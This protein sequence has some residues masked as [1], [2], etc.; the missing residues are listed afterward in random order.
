MIVAVTAW[1]GVGSTTTALLLAAHARSAGRAT[2]LVETDPAGG[3]LAGRIGLPVEAVGGLER[4][5]FP[6]AAECSLESV[7]ADWH[8]VRL[9][10]APADPFRAHACHHPSRQ[11]LPELADLAADA[12]VVIDIGRMRAASPSAELLDMADLVVLVT[13]PEVSAAVGA[14][15]WLAAAGR[16]S[17]LDTA[18][19]A[20]DLRVVVVDSPGGVS[21]RRALL[22]AELG[23]R[24]LGWL[25][26]ETSTVDRLHRTG[27]LEPDRRRRGLFAEATTLGGRV[28]AFETTTTA[29][30][31]AFG[32]R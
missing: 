19:T 32:A 25:P 24:L 21:F 1:R 26:W 10:S 17:A 12:V 30:I 27:R 5:A 23:D 22:E 11:W 13:S 2:W 9:V 18:T 8:G 28:M 14:S 15:E 4:R 6:G 3:V 29:S 7:A 16:V 31:A 20:T